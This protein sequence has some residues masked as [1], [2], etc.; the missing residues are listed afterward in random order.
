MV[1]SINSSFYRLINAAFYNNKLEH[2]RYRDWKA[3]RVPIEI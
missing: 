1:S 2:S 3:Y